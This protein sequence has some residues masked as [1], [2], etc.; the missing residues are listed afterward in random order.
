MTPKPKVIGLNQE[1]S[2][3]R[4]W[5]KIVV[6]NH[7]SFPV[8]SGHRDNVVGIVSV[9]AIYANLAAGAGVTLKNLMVRPLVVPE[10]Q[11]VLQLVECFKERGKHIAM[12]T[13]EFG[14]IVGLVTL[15]DVM[16]A[17]IGRFPSLDERSKP[18]AVRREDGSWLVDALLDIASVERALP[19]FTLAESERSGYQTMAGFIMQR[20][21]RVPREGD[22]FEDQGY[23]FEVIDMDG[24]RVDKVLVLPSITKMDH[25]V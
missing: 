7:S 23:V 13:D 20:F 6:S 8:Y 18:T 9:K 24:H 19:G 25:T 5:H 1:D 3:E 4:I 22:S 21:G 11:S 15:I 12:V 2:H 14:S 17:I 10:T 16:E